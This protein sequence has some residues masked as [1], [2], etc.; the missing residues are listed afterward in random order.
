MNWVLFWKLILIF[1][2]SAYSLLVIIVF[3]GGIKNIIE[4]LKELGAPRDQN[5]D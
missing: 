1:T 2:I 3:F 4:M 5:T